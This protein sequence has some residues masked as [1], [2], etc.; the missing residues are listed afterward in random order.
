MK[1]LDLMI[2]D[3]NYTYE[4]YARVMGINNTAM[5][6]FF[7]IYQSNTISQKDICEITKIPKQTVNTVVK[8]YQR[9]RFIE[10]VPGKEDRRQKD[11]HLTQTGMEF[12]NKLLPP[13][14]EAERR[15]FEHLSKSKQEQL[16]K[17][18]D[19]Y[20]QVFQ[21]EMHKLVEERV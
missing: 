18:F 5:Y 4:Q 21:E 16:L 9:K 10:A 2:Q 6:I 20:N 3:V 1:K 15:A 12:C 8:E 19:E 14:I 11:L 13:V 7:L 17:L